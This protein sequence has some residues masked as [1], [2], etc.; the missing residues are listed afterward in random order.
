MKR[1]LLIVVIYFLSF[2]SSFAQDLE[3]R[4]KL[5]PTKNIWTFLK[6]DTSTGLIWQVQF[7]TQGEDY[8]F[9]TPL[10]TTALVLDKNCPSGRFE[11]YPSE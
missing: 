2:S 5:Y 3:P 8:R 4:F 1:C 10:N 6:L 9:E 7:S 11:L